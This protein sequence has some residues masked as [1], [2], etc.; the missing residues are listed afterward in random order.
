MN[1]IQP[2]NIK[3]SSV[4]L[5]S[6]DD[7]LFSNDQNSKEEK[8]NESNRVKLTEISSSTGNRYDNA[9][10]DECTK[11]Q[12]ND[13]IFDKILKS[14]K[15]PKIPIPFMKIDGKQ[16]YLFEYHD[17]H[18]AYKNGLMNLYELAKFGNARDS[19]KAYSKYDPKRPEA[20]IVYENTNN[21][22]NSFLHIK[23][24]LKG[25]LNSLL[26]NSTPQQ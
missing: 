26:K 14:I 12:P 8:L 6:A 7:I 16:L 21:L 10:K 11:I 20:K 2:S 19:S 5:K 9:F 22:W 4:P 13:D 18:D 17:D 25:M 1:N 23:D 24:K 3:I 15:V